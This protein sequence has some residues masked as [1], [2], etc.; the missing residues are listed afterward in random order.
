MGL[1]VTHSGAARIGPKWRHQGCESLDLQRFGQR[2]SVC[3]APPI[4]SFACLGMALVLLNLP[5]QNGFALS[6]PNSRHRLQRLRHDF[7]LPAGTPHQM[8][9]AERQM[10]IFIAYETRR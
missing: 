7:F 9:L 4:R 6:Q 8:I 10:F 2:S 5:Q 3:F 1:P